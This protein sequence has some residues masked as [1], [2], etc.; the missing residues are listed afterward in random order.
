MGT[1]NPM[2]MRLLVSLLLC[3]TAMVQG[4]NQRV[5]L[6][7]HAYNHPDFLDFQCRC[8]QKFLEDDYTFIV[9]NDAR[10]GPM[11]DAIVAMCDKWDVTCIPIPQ[12]LHD[13]P[14][15]EPFW[16]NDSGAEGTRRHCDG[17]QYSLDVI[18]YDFDGIVVIIDSD[19]FPLKPININQLFDEGHDIVAITRGPFSGGIAVEY[20]WPGLTM[21]AMN[22]LPDRKT[23]DF[24]CGNIGGHLV[25]SGGYTHYYLK[26][27]P[28]V[29]VKSL[30]YFPEG[31]I[32][33]HCR[34]FPAKQREK[35]YRRLNFNKREIDWIFKHPGFDIEFYHYNHFLHFNCGRFSQSNKEAILAELMESILAD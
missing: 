32:Y 31:C 33:K 4:A 6:I 24:K 13:H 17:I 15:E 11:H 5:L 8:F 10:P 9:F 21:M 35:I 16:Q 2:I 19:C 23:L 1:Y 30:G 34:D 27:H 26:N 14:Q 3:L 29:K 20:L 22:R 28:E 7:T 25:D 18:G 12:E